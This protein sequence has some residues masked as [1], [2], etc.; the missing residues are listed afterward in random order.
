MKSEIKYFAGALL[1]TAAVVACN[2]KSSNKPAAAPAPP[3]A[4][5]VPAP[6]VQN[7]PKVIVEQETLETDLLNMEKVEKDTR[8]QGIQF[9]TAEQNP[10]LAKK[11]KKQVWIKTQ[12]Y[13][14]WL[15]HMITQMF[16]DAETFKVEKVTSQKPRVT[17][18]LQ[19][20]SLKATALLETYNKPFDVR[21]KNGKIVSG[22]EAMKALYQI[23][24]KRDLAEVV[25]KALNENNGRVLT[26][27]FDL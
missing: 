12:T 10:E 22:V 9:V 16:N 21:L 11:N 2:S 1:L 8:R 23:K 15:R 18:Y 14:I 6:V 17:V 26:H 19:D 3:A 24:L 5:K 4:A 13:N 25:I 7:T 27:S 20:Y